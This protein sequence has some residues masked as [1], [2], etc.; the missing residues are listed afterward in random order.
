[1][2]ENLANPLSEAKT[3]VDKAADSI[4]GLL[5][6]QAE[7]KKPQAEAETTQQETQEQPQESS[8]EEQ[9]EVQEPKEETEVESQEETSEEQEV[10]SQEEQDEIPQEQ[11]STY[12]VKVA[13]QEFDVTLDELKSGYSRDSDYRRKTEELSLERKKFQTDAEKQRQDFSSRLTELNNVMSAAKEQL[14]SEESKIDLEKLYDED[15]TEAARVDHKLRRKRE[16][17]DQAVKVAQAEQQKQFEQVLQD[18]K[19]KLVS[20]MPDFADPNKASKIKNDMRSYL[21]G[22][23]FQDPE[24]AQIYDHRI[25]MLVNDAMKYRNLQSAKPNLAKKISKPSKVFKSGIKPTKADV[26]SKSYKE[27]LSR[28]KKTGHMNDAASVFLDLIN[29]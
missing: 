14:D 23:G 5:N 3:D 9:S 22:Y 15:P 17:Y 20:K 28:L 24:I 6:P 1:M 11:N 27:K 7:E 4:S 21:S 2:S 16:K 12:K 13:G 10:A 26:N 25:V 29:K 8:T 18:Q 19:Q